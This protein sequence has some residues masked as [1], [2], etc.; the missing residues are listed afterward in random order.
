MLPAQAKVKELKHA[1]DRAYMMDT[2]A[3]K[4]VYDSPLVF[5]SINVDTWKILKEE[6]YWRLI[7]DF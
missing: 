7:M 6:R 3:W 1:F 2:S 4:R 5:C